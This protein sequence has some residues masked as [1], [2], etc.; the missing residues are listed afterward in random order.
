LVGESS[1]L[2]FFFLLRQHN[3]TLGHAR[4]NV[5]ARVSGEVYISLGITGAR[6][7]T[8]IILAALMLCASVRGDIPAYAP[9]RDWVEKRC[10]TNTV[11]KD[12]RVFIGHG[13]APDYATI[14]Q[15]RKGMGLREIIDETPYKGKM[16]TILVMRAEDTNKKSG[17]FFREVKPSEKPDFQVKPL[18]L[19]WIYT[20]VPIF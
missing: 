6:M 20:G 12:E 11:P 13:S 7:R 19:I 17:C 8:I 18:D 16:V 9:M 15:H 2:W 10:T 14:I 5:L 1:L 4:R 3:A